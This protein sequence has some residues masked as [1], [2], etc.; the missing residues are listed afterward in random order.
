MVLCAVT[1]SVRCASL[2]AATAVWCDGEQPVFSVETES[3]Q[4][5]RQARSMPHT[6]PGLFY[7]NYRAAQ[8]GSRTDL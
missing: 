4:R 8:Q 3:T 7:S 1:K 5:N 2:L 6:L